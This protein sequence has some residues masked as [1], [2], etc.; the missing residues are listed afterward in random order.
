V[1]LS[2]GAKRKKTS[3]GLLSSEDLK[4]GK[5]ITTSCLTVAGRRGL[6][7]SKLTSDQFVVLTSFRRE[8]K[9]KIKKLSAKATLA[10]VSKEMAKPKAAT[11]VRE[12]LVG[13]SVC[14][15]ARGHF[16]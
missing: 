6:V 7:W 3:D 13:R 4:E 1:P 10:E 16:F 9:K 15:E 8:G 2:F 12:Y 14:T 11:S 5:V